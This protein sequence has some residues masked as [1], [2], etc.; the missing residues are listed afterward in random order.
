MAAQHIF[1]SMKFYGIYKITNL[2]NGKMYIGQHITDNL[3]DGYMGSGRIIKEAVKKH[4]AEN[5]RKEWVMF[6]EDAD[7]LN[8]WESVF[9]DETWVER[10]DTYNLTTGG[11]Q[12]NVM[13]AQTRAKMSESHKG[14]S[15]A[16]K[17]QKWNS[18]QCKRHSD[19]MKGHSQNWKPGERDKASK[20][21]RD[22][23]L[24][25]EPWN[26]GKTHIYSDETL[27]QMSES[28]KCRFSDK[29]KHPQYGKPHTQQTKAKISQTQ[30]VRQ[31]GLCWCNNGVVNKFV[32]PDEIPP[33]FVRGRICHRNKTI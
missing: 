11:K 13:S 33:G 16:N 22:Y 27:L 24:S 6:C 25:H 12:N 26:K 30:S 21:M 7:E 4:G 29:T 19:R 32:S 20:R 17:G 14:K 31:T 28:A 18:E 2:L 15:P 10:A 5:F 1:Y 23:N 8:Y 9:V 3:D